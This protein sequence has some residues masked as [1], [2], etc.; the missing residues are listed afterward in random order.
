MKLDLRKKKF[1]FLIIFE[2]IVTKLLLVYMTYIYSYVIFVVVVVVSRCFDFDEWN[3]FQNNS[4]HRK[5]VW[6]LKKYLHIEGVTNRIL[7]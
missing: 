6:K 1:E 7:H 2:G 5:K 4:H 3:K